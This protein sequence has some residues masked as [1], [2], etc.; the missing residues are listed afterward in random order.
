MTQ[1]YGGQGGDLIA[2]NQ[3][4]HMK[5]MA[6][7]YFKLL[8]RVMKGYKQLEIMTD[9]MSEQLDNDFEKHE[10]VVKAEERMREAKNMLMGLED[11]LE[12]VR[13]ARNDAAG[14]R[15]GGHKKTLDQYNAVV[16]YAKEYD[17]RESA[18]NTTDA[19]CMGKEILG[20]FQGKMSDCAHRCDRM[21]HPQKCFAF[22]HYNIVKHEKKSNGEAPEY[23]R[24][25]WWNEKNQ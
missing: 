8:R 16:E 24:C 19:M 4:Q 20:A 1:I 2:G 18:T 13:K 12:A 3:A 17:A 25:K 5:V 7:K 22:Q 11:E 14:Y 21:L 23:V 10:Q 9:K 15:G 6:G